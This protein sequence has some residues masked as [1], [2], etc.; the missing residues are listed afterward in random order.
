MTKRKVE[1]ETI[2]P[3]S[4]REPR[5]GELNYE[6]KRILVKHCL[7]KSLKEAVKSV[8]LAVSRI[9]RQFN[10]HEFEVTYDRHASTRNLPKPWINEGI[11]IRMYRRRSNGTLAIHRAGASTYPHFFPIGDER[12]ANL[13]APRDLTIFYGIDDPYDWKHHFVNPN[14]IPTRLLAKWKLDGRK[15]F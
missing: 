4:M 1:I 3:D 14:K 5:R 8:Q 13:S 15:G 11:S 7:E 2:Y 10:I 6:L 9:A 12:Y